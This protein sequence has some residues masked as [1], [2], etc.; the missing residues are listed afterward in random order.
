MKRGIKKLNFFRNIF[1]YFLEKNKAFYSKVV[2]FFNKAKNGNIKL[3]IST[4][5]YLKVLASIVKVRNINFIGKYDYFFKGFEELKVVSID[6]SEAQLGAYIRSKY[7]TRTPEVID[8]GY[9][10]SYKCGEF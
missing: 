4:L 8:I 6:F 5:S 7:G 3:C 2:G 9:A 10:L 1:I